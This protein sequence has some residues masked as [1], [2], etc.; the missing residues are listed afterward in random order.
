MYGVTLPSS[1]V[2]SLPSGVGPEERC[3]HEKGGGGDACKCVCVCGGGGLWVC[4]RG[5]EGAT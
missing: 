4:A 2:T 3:E 1:A 5:G